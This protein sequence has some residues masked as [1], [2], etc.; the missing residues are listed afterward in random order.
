MKI[1]VV[2]LLVSWKEAEEILVQVFKKIQ[3]TQNNRYCKVV[4]IQPAAFSLLLHV[5]NSST[6]TATN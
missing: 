1:K 6:I 5:E 4:V 3:N 2:Q